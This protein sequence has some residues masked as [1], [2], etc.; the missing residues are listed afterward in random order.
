MLFLQQTPVKTALK[1]KQGPGVI[2]RHNCISTTSKLCILGSPNKHCNPWQKGK[3]KQS[4][5]SVVKP[6]TPGHLGWGHLFPF[7]STPKPG[8]GGSSGPEGTRQ[9]VSTLGKEPSL[10]PGLLPE[11]HLLADLGLPAATGTSSA[12]P[13]NEGRCP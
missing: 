7:I 6:V 1:R 12:A 8:A 4:S 13:R 5:V 2:P 11:N 3:G 10:R 9:M